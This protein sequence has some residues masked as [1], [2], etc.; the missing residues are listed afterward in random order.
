MIPVPLL[1]YDSSLIS[2]DLLKH[3]RIDHPT[4][5]AILPQWGSP[6][7]H[8]RYHPFRACPENRSWN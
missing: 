8:S 6:S 4:G 3:C 5:T 2:D 7:S 1:P